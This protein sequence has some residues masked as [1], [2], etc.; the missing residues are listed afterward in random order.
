MVSVRWVYSASIIN[1][2]GNEMIEQAE[3][4]NIPS[5]V[6]SQLAKNGMFVNEVHF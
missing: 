5:Y 3:M 4:L 6:K 2:Y 1:I